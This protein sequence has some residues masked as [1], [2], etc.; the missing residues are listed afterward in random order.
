M[1]L[2]LGLLILRLLV[3]GLF[4]GHGAQKLWGAFGGYGLKGVAGWLE[5]LG[6]RPAWFWALLAGASEFGGGLLLALGLLN[7]LGP[8]AIIGAML[9]AIAKVHWSKGLWVTNN[10]IEY[11][12]VLLVLSAI[13]GLVGPGALSL[14]ALLGIQ[15][16][17][18]LTFW[19]GLLAVIVV[20]AY[21]LLISSQA[22]SGNTRGQTA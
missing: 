14:D 6:L 15:L 20:N 11:P 3:G 4:I 7:P 2:D 13:L 10:G 8:L 22:S 21:A 1:S 12:L 9:M 18:A 16:P 17:L 19:G 5:S